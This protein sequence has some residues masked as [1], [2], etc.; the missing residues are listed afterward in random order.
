MGKNGLTENVKPVFPTQTEFVGKAPLDKSA[1][2]NI[3]SHPK[4]QEPSQWDG[5]FEYLKHIS[6]LV[7]K[8]I[9]E[10]LRK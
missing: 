10:F 3:I 5:S 9:I 4:S 7:G 8:K 2:W 1:N 6:K